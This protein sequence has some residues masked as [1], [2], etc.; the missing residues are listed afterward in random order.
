M[1]SS[2]SSS[3]T[4]W[5]ACARGGENELFDHYMLPEHPFLLPVTEGVRARRRIR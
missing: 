5:G 4:A 1:S 2:L 3:V